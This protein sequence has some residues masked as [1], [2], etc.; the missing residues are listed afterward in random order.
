MRGGPVVYFFSNCF[1]A[2]MAK[3]CTWLSMD[4]SPMYEGYDDCADALYNRQ[5]NVIRSTLV[6]MGGGR[7]LPACLGHRRA[8]IDI[9]NDID[10][11]CSKKNYVCGEVRAQSIPVS[12]QGILINPLEGCRV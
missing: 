11:F 12:M 6:L 7:K 5:P 4:V 3:L 8:L 1:T 2:A 10:L 9:H